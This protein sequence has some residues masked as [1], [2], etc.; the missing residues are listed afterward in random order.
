MIDR[1]N[2]PSN[3]PAVFIANHAGSLGPIASVS[4]IPFRL[5]PWIVSDMLSPQKSADYLRMDYV[6]KELK[7]KP[8]LSIFISRALC[9]ITVPLL[10]YFG[11]IPVH[12][13]IGYQEH[14]NTLIASLR[15]L[16]EGKCLLVFPENTDWE[17]DPVTQIHR[18]S[19]SVLWLGDLYYRETQK[20]LP[21]YPVAIHPSR[22]LK[23][24]QPFEYIPAVLPTYGGKE[25][26]ILWLEDLIKCMYLSLAQR[27]NS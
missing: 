1:E 16:K 9:R 23:I 26:L 27:G 5:Y 19:K 17:K 25:G 20:P 22:M 21:F 6:E 11:C 13:G 10:T 12:K 2:F 18:F 14:K 3:G 7:L 8:P 24:G 4:S 15:L